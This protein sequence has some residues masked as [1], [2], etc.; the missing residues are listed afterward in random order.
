MKDKHKQRTSRSKLGALS[1]K[2]KNSLGIDHHQERLDTYYTFME[3]T[4]NNTCTNQW[5]YIMFEDLKNKECW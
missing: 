5:G 3:Q 2:H 1:T 4:K